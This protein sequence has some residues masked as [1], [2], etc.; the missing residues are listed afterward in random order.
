MMGNSMRKLKLFRLTL[1]AG[2][3]FSLCPRRT[4][5]FVQDTQETESQPQS[6]RLPGAFSRF[7]AAQVLKQ[8]FADYDPKTG[9]VTSIPD[10]VVRIDKARLWKAQGEERLMV[11]VEMGDAHSIG[12]YM[13]GNL[14][15]PFIA[16][17]RTSIGIAICRA[18]GLSASANNAS[19]GASMGKSS[20]R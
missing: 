15:P 2:L 10:S 19:G 1:L 6:V 9:R 17:I 12:P 20:F 18:I 16:W 13:C 14:R 8:I 3:C 5:G 7:S 4:G 11:L